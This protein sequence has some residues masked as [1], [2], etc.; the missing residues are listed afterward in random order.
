M[1]KYPFWF[2]CT[3]EAVLFIVIFITSYY[4]HCT[5]QERVGSMSRMNRFSE[6]R[7]A[8]LMVQMYYL[9]D[10]KKKISGYRLY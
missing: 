1:S 5:S 3:I 4:E 8:K 7:G 2:N 10:P 6:K 9:L